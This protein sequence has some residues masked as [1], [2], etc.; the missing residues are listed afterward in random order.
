M[1][2]FTMSTITAATTVVQPPFESAAFDETQLAAASFLARY[3]GRTLEAYRHDLRGFFQWATDARV[4]VLAA[5]RLRTPARRGGLPVTD[6][7]YTTKS[8]KTLT[9]ADIE[10]LA[11]EAATTDYDIETLKRRRRG[12]PLIGSAPA[13]VVPVRLDPELRAAVEARATADQTTTSDVIREALR[14]FLDVA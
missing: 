8:G 4:D 5:T 11:D 6:K 10:Q 7:T 12:R 1:R 14:R 13:E 2:R 3:S 9:D